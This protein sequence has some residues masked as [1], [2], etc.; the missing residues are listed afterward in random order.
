MLSR[1]KTSLK[2]KL[3]AYGKL[4]LVVFLVC[5]VL[6]NVCVAYPLYWLAIKGRRPDLFGLA[7]VIHQGPWD[8]LMAFMVLAVITFRRKRTAQLTSVPDEGLG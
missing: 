7:V 8:F 6:K 2:Q 3:D 1:L 5:H 4:G